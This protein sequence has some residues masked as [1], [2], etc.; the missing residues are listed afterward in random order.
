MPKQ[1]RPKETINKS[2]KIIQRATFAL[3]ISLTATHTPLRAQHNLFKP[4]PIDFYSKMVGHFEAL[5]ELVDQGRIQSQEMEKYRLKEIRKHSGINH[6]KFVSTIKA[7]VTA[8]QSYPDC[9]R[10]TTTPPKNQKKH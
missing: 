2:T 8:Q 1:I 7:Y 5:C 3:L 6:Q 9:F 4:L 10:A